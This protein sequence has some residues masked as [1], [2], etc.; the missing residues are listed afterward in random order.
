MDRMSNFHFCCVVKHKVVKN[1]TLKFL[2][3]LI[4]H[5]KD[6]LLGKDSVLKSSIP[7]M[8]TISDLYLITVDTLN[9]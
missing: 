2:E 8:F 4:Y 9:K 3:Y 1:H 5:C 7:P 6:S